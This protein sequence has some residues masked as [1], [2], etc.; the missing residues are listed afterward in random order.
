MSSRETKAEER[1]RLKAQ[2]QKTTY[3]KQVAEWRQA[4]PWCLGVLRPKGRDYECNCREW[5]YNFTNN[6]YESTK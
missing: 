6:Q 1:F 5:S 3:T 2:E 4:C